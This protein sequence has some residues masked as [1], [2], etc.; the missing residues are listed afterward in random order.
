MKQFLQKILNWLNER[1][2]VP[3]ANFEITDFEQD[4]R[5]KVTFNW[6]SA[7]IK[8]IHAMG[9]QAETEEDSVQLFF[10]T[11]SLRP[12]QLASQDEVVVDN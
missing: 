3:Y 11:A 12:T 9:F 7:F 1:S 5:V 4:G 6:N 8:K 2:K 10:Y